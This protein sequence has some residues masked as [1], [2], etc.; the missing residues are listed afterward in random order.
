MEK[1]TGSAL[2]KAD[3]VDVNSKTFNSLFGISRRKVLGPTPIRMEKYVNASDVEVI[4]NFHVFLW[5]KG[6]IYR[7]LSCATNVNN[8]PNLLS[9]DVIYTLGVI[10][11]CYSVESSNLFS[12]NSQAAPTPHSVKFGVSKMH[13]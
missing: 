8:L 13:G 5:W 1:S 12:G 7:Q 3:T 2:L 4:E 6:K 10:R 9:R 11:P